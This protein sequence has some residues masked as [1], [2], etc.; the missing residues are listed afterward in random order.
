MRVKQICLREEGEDYAVRM[1]D[2]PPS[3]QPREKYDQ[4]GPEHL[5][6]SDLL[7]LI[8][9]TGAAGV[10]VVQLAGGLLYRYGSLSAL[11]RASTAELQKFHGIGKEKAKILKAALELGRRLSQENIGGQ[12]Y[13]KEP[14][15][16]A[17]IL[18]ER[19]RAADREHLWVLLLDLKHRLIVPPVEVFRGT[20][21]S[22]L[23]HPREVFKPAIQHSASSMIVAHNHPSG[24]PEPSPNDIQITLRLIAAGKTLG[25][26]VDDHVIIGRRMHDGQD[27]FISIRETGRV[28]FSKDG[29]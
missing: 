25:I 9:R 29:C 14:A 6:D 24:D 13:V 2:L 3:M 23:S 12:P 1:Q 5:A 19:A 20:L 16:V 7:A 11:L 21:T 8:L 28:I 27:D 10:N 4:V 17:A 26:G 22:T 18:R 15:D